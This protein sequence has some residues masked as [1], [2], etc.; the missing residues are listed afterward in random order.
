MTYKQ[1]S[2]ELNYHNRR[3]NDMIAVYEGISSTA[4][5]NQILEQERVIEAIGYWMDR[6][7]QIELLKEGV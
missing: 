4:G 5:T 2:N 1:L 3:L 7:E 6:R